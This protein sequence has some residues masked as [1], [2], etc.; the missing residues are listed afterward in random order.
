MVHRF[1]YSA[2][3]M[4]RCTKKKLMRPLGIRIDMDTYM[5]IERIAQREDRTIG[6]VVR[7]LLR[8]ALRKVA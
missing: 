8:E 1:G 3:K 6:Y 4:K 5:A 2:T 7:R